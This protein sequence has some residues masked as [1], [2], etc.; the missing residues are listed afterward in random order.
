MMNVSIPSSLKE[1]EVH[2]ME[3]VQGKGKH[4]TPLQR[5]YERAEDVY[6]KAKNTN[7]NCILWVN[8]TVIL[9]QIMMQR[10]CV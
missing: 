3:L 9:K 6:E 8:A 10:L 5:L 7:S 4:K 2:H 1:I